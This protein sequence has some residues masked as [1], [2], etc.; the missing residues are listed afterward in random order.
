MKVPSGSTAEVWG[1]TGGIAAGKSL[2]ARLFKEVGEAAGAE[3]A[4]MDAD[5]LAR[6]LSLPGG[7]AHAD[8]LKRF[9]TNDRARLRQMVFSD[10]RARKDLEALLHPRITAASQAQMEQIEKKHAALKNGTPCRIL[11]EAALLVETGRYHDFQGLIVIEAPCEL[12]IQRLIQRDGISAELAQQI[13]NSQASDEQRAKAA[14]VVLHNSGS[15]EDLRCA[16][17]AWLQS[18]GW[19]P[20]ASPR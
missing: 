5:A 9:G 12:R 15:A 13:L 18:Q 8:I 20:S 2:A 11:Y 14:T 17:Q 16:I 6:E 1:L 4:V 3:I 7:A 19:L 10:P